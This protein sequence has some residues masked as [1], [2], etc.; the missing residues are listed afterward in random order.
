[1]WSLSV[2]GQTAIFRCHVTGDPRPS[3]EWSCGD[4]RPVMAGDRVR[5]YVD[6]DGSHVLELDDV[7]AADAGE[8]TVAASNEL[9]SCSATV[10]LVVD[11]DKTTTVSQP[12]PLHDML[13]ILNHYTTYNK[14]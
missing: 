8:Y 10:A 6:D 3:V 7:R 5:Q 12:T 2:A 14:S 1:M 9:G 11:M 13:V 4:W